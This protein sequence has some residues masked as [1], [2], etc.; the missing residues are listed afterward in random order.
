MTH[1]SLDR[2]FYLTV[3]NNF[4]PMNSRWLKRGQFDRP[5]TCEREQLSKHV[6]VATL[7]TDLMSVS[8]SHS[9]WICGDLRLVE[10]TYLLFTRMPG[11]CCCVLW[12]L[13][14]AITSLWWK[15][16]SLSPRKASHSR[17]TLPSL[18]FEANQGGIRKYVKNE[19]IWVQREPVEAGFPQGRRSE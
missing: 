14:S 15:F 19:S 8:G 13:S 3:Q 17:V 16:G 18:V 1:H 2:Q 5:Y 10:F 4:L 9:L 7:L 12:R 11:V 6:D